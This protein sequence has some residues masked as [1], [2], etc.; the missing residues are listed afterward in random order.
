MADNKQSPWHIAGLGAIGSLCN[1]TALKTSNCAIPIIRKNS[2]SFCTSF[3]DISG[4]SLQLTAPKTIGD[5]DSVKKIVVPLK[6]YDVL[7]FLQQIALKLSDAAQVILCHNGMGTIDKALDLLPTTTNL[8]F[9]TSSHGVFKQGRQAHYAGV[10]ESQWQLI[11]AGNSNELSNKD[12][13]AVLPNAKKAENLTLLLWQKLIVNCAINPLT[14]IYKVKNGELADTR[15]QAVITD[16]VQEAVNVA[17]TCNVNIELDFM[18]ERVYQVIQQ[19][20]AN[21]SSMLQ[22]VVG[23]RRTEISFITGYLIEQAQQHSLSVPVNTEL[24]NK[25]TKL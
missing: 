12:L 14:A 24:F 19:T 15:F 16:I 9:C 13:E 11:K 17:Q 5:I 22:D 4:Q 6:S 23:G 3:V 21:T 18:L 8:Y 2:N 25:V 7:P 10:G 1:A 20:S